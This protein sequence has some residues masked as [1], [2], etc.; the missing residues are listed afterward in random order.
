[1]YL[2]LFINNFYIF[3]AIIKPLTM[4]KLNLLK[5]IVDFI[6]IMSL[7]FYPL[8]IIF[9]VMVL[10]D[11]E[12]FDIPI[13]ILGTSVDLSTGYGKIA[14]II[15]VLNF[16]LLLYA[17]YFFRKLLTLFTKRIIFDDEICLLL[18][19]IGSLVIYASIVYL[20]SDFIIK[21]S[22]STVEIQFGY[23]PFL[24]LLALGLFFKV[25][26]EVFTIGKRIKEENEL[27]I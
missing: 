14:L 4:K 8:I 27:T 5:T 13:K 10:I 2:L 22:N 15:T 17:V 19:K 7:I 3:V 26:S 9:S 18:D 21:L 23:G 6:W 12:V 20:I 16:G 1:M 11:K 24:Y 25:L